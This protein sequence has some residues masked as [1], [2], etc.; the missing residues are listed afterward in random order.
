MPRLAFAQS[1]WDGYDTLE[2]IGR[3]EWSNGKVSMSGASYLGMSQWLCA[4]LRSQYLTCM[5]PRVAAR[6][7]REPSCSED[8]ETTAREADSPKR[9]TWAGRSP[10]SVTAK[11]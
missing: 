4:P 1:F 7:R 5:T 9:R 2:W 10:G 11:P 3:Q 6:P 8:T